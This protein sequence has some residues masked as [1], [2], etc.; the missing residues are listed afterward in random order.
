MVFGKMGSEF[1]VFGPINPALI[2]PFI[3]NNKVSVEKLNE[4]IKQ[5]YLEVSEKIKLSKIETNER[6]NENKID[7]N[8]KPGDYVFVLDRLNIPGNPRV[9]RTRFHP[10]PYVVVR[11][12]WTTTL[13]RRL[14]DGFT[15]L[16]SNDDL[17][18]Y[19]GKSPLFKD[20]PA[21]IKR[22][23]L[24]DFQDLL[25]QDFNEMTKI[26]TLELPSG[27]QLFTENLAPTIDVDDDSAQEVSFEPV[28]EEILAETK[29]NI[30]ADNLSPPLTQSGVIPQNMAELAEESAK[31]NDFELP[32]PNNSIPPEELVKNLRALEEQER[33]DGENKTEPESDS[34][35]EEEEEITESPEIVPRTSGR[36]RKKTV[37]FD[38]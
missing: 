18:V 4:E 15:S 35:S 21:E 37:K 33:E 23:L 24:H 31:D 32:S 10:S 8:F 28:Q 14:A 27:I 25:A 30:P 2:H 3:A 38:L 16:Y 34:E 1:S 20:L 29:Q 11:P 26:D 36:I 5:I 19:D 13:V 6:L 22:I 17:K 9:L 12:L 7:K